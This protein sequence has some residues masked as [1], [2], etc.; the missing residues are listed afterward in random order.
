[1]HNLSAIPLWIIKLS[2]HIVLKLLQSLGGKC[3]LLSNQSPNPISEIQFHDEHAIIENIL[4]LIEVTIWTQIDLRIKMKFFLI[5]Q[6]FLMFCI[7]MHTIN[8]NLCRVLKICFL[9]QFAQLMAIIQ[10]IRLHLLSWTFDK[11][12]FDTKFLDLIQHCCFQSIKKCHKSFRSCHLMC[13]QKKAHK[14]G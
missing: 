9:S 8:S 14:I 11:V 6:K 1:M 10:F 2:I 13:H 3:A 4:W 12:V 5:H 7:I